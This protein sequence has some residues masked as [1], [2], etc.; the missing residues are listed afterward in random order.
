MS[1]EWLV[2]EQQDPVDNPERTQAAIAIKTETML[3]VFSH[4]HQ[5]LGTAVL[6]VLEHPDTPNRDPCEESIAVV[7]SSG[8]KGTDNFICI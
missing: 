8:G 6:N 3:R 1:A 4:S 7:L 5:D 2:C